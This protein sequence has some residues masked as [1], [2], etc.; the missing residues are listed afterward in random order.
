[1]P[2]YTAPNGFEPVQRRDG[3]PYAGMTREY[4]IATGY[5]TQLRRG[6][7]VRLLDSGA[8]VKCADTTAIAGA[9]TTDSGIL[10]IFM[11]CSYTDPVLG[12]TFRTYWTASTAAADAKAMVVDDPDVIWRAIYVSGGV[13]VSAQTRAATLGKNLSIIQNTTKTQTS[14]IAVS[15]VATT[16]TLPLR[17]VDV[18]PDS[19]ASATT[20]T[21]LFV[22]YGVGMHAW[23]HVA[24]AA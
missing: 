3:L 2:V 19:A 11:G 6:D 18:D 20:Y 16:A 8:L 17:C 24:A 10:G 21:A 9:D 5:A 7:L 1:M 4:P 22:T 15:G 14:D 12:K 13:T 23:T